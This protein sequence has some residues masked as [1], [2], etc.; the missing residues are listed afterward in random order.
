MPEFYGLF[1][2]EPLDAH[3]VSA[4]TPIIRYRDLLYEAAS[5][6]TPR[7]VV[8]KPEWHAADL[9]LRVGF[10]LTNLRHAAGGIVRFHNGRG[11][12]ER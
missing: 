10:I 3:G 12:A 11:T 9:F 6:N 1:C 4:P 8:A 5:W 2:S 7:P